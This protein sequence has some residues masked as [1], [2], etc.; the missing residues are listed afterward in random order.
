MFS[1]AETD[2]EYR[3]S[4]RKRR[5][6]NTCRNNEKLVIFSEENIDE[7]VIRSLNQNV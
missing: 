4:K 7:T 6:R 3:L 5:K 2:T 1:E